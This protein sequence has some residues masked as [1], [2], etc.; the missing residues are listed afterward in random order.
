MG[1]LPSNAHITIRDF[2]I[3][4]YPAVQRLWE[5]AGL[6]HRPRGRDSPERVAKEITRDS[7]VFLVADAGDRLAGVVFGTH[8]GRKGWVNRLAVAPAYQ[9]K[10]VARRLVREVEKRLGSQGIEITAALIETENEDSAAFFA[11][12]GY[13][14]GADIE[15]FSKRRS[16][17]T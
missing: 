12:I 2:T 4:D 8:D 9:R 16:A 11:A 17:D 3:A 10:G 15:Y 7:S 1:E 5:E 13:D 14:H 6:S